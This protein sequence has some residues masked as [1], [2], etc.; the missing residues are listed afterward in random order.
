VARSGVVNYQVGSA[1]H[2]N[3]FTTNYGNLYLKYFDGTS[4]HS[5]SNLGNPGAV[6]FGSPTAINYAAPYENVFVED[7]NYN[8]D[9]AWTPNG[10]SWT[11]VKLGNPGAKLASNPAVANY[12]VGKAL[13]E[14]VFAIDQNGNLDLKFWDGSKWQNWVN[15]GNPGVSL[16]TG[17]DPSVINYGNFE[18]VFVTD[19]QGNLNYAWSPDG[20]TW[21]NWTKLGNPG[22]KVFGDPAAINYQAPYANV[23]VEEQDANADLAYIYWN[24]AQWNWVKLGNP[25]VP[26]LGAPA[27]I[28]YPVGSVLHE[29][30]FVGDQNRNLDAVY[31]DGTS[32]HWTTTG[33]AGVPL[34]GDPAVN[35]ITVGGVL[36][37][38][39][40][41]VDQNYD[42][43]LFFYTG[44]KWYWESLGT[45]GTT[46]TA[47]AAIS[48]SANGPAV[49]ESQTGALP[50]ADG[51]QTGAPLAISQTQNTD[52]LF[53]A[54][55]ASKEELGLP[56]AT[57]LDRLAEVLLS[58]V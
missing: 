2:E 6:L 54:A 58:R 4:W 48:S 56:G 50:A 8:L 35:N 31:W 23:F 34:F 10:T 29:N 5:A 19:V 26:L 15:L 25:G 13:Y 24:G 46:P 55:Q 47:S 18:D 12:Q 42:L 14:N 7:G 52:D 37:E 49:Q 30:V 20:K 53:F 36:H 21:G 41:V 1:L 17:H 28:N 3:V 22:V 11:W 33:N 45:V 39:V 16:L 43:D 38:H 40:L 9:Y 51:P 32:W 27:A 44:V 57:E